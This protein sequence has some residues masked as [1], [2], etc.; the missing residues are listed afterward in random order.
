MLHIV[1]VEPEIPQNTGNISRTCAVTGAALHLVR[2]LGFTITDSKLK[3]AGLDY[4][5]QLTL[6]YHDSFEE[7][8]QLFPTGRFFLCSTHAKSSYA[9]A[10]FEDGDILVF[11]KE[12]AGLPKPLLERRSKD[13]I[14]IPMKPAERSLNLSNAVA[15]VLYEALRQCGFPGLV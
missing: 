15:V 8:E 6:F 3:R 11:G 7:V 5:D 13:I 2:P 1:L 9:D 4:W 12:T 14:R 10:R